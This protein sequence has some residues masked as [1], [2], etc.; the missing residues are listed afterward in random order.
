MRPIKRGKG[1]NASEEALARL[2]D[3]TFLDLWSYPNTFKKPGQELCDLLVV[4]GDDVIVF[5]DKS[6][7]WTEADITIAWSRWYKKAI[8]KSADQ[9]NGAIRWIDEHPDRIFLDAACKE[10]FPIPLPAKERR[11][12]H[13]ICIA[14]GSE[15]AASKHFNDADGTFFITPYLKGPDHT[16]FNVDGHMPFSI[17]DVTPDGAF[18]HVFNPLTL[19]VVMDE[20]DTVTDFVDYLS[21]RKELLRSGRLSI[22]PSEAE[23]LANYM[24]T[25]DGERNCFPT[26]QH[27]GLT[28]DHKVAYAQGEY[29]YFVRSEEYKY[30]RREDAISYA[31]DTLIGQFTKSVIAG[32]SYKILNVD[33]SAELAERALSI[34]A[35]ESRFA[36][37][38]LGHAFVGA[39]HALHE[40]KMDR[41][42]RFVMPDKVLSQAN[43]SY[44]F[45]AMRLDKFGDYEEYRTIRASMLETYCM[46]VLHDNRNIQTCVGLA[47]DAIDNPGCSEDLIVTRQ[48]EWTDE[49]VAVLT[50]RRNV[51]EILI[52]P[53]I[54]TSTRMQFTEYKTADT[55][56]P[57]RQQRRAAER[58][59]KKRRR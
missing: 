42:A 54:L 27:A 6:I 28:D 10:Y 37:R 3:K 2:A 26:A 31:W 45:M 23:L 11:R 33:P 39:V 35:R 49:E 40:Q 15:R 25:Y 38:V 50:E 20:L 41:L 36:R 52:E 19:S 46:S 48:S 4:C 34:M 59:A 30:R 17:G 21:A 43:L 53:S 29:A 51:Y 56:P 58:A 55:K 16:N 1:L 12:V 7:D 8:K 18:T 57:S 22:A 24:Q 47:I 44:V 9:I 14:S 5:S 13:G 32:T